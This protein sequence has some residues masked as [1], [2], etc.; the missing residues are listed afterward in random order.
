MAGNENSGRK[1]LPAVVHMAR[2]NPSRK[3]IGELKEGAICWEMLND[4]PACPSHLDHYAQEEWDRLAPDLY[5][6]G[7]INKLDQAELA[8]YCTAYSD[9][10]RARE[11]I[12]STGEAGMIGETPNG[13]KQMSVWLQIANRAEERM[14]KAGASFGFSPAARARLKP[15]QIQ[16]TLFPNEQGDAADKY[17]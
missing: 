13:F 4:I 17:F 7:L 6:I 5:M 10:R 9:W 3:P 8:I 14:Q 1:P 11:V 15:T 12:S 2:G 16:G